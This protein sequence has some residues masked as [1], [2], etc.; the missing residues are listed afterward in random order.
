VIFDEINEISIKKSL[1]LI[2]SIVDWCEQNS[3]EIEL[4]APILKKNILFKSKLLE[5]A[6]TLNY[7]RK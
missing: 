2:D 7:I 1:S 6:L 4:I 5:E 3:I